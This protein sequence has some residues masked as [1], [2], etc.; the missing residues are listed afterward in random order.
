M[1]EKLLA[2]FSLPTDD[3]DNL[4]FRIIDNG[5][6]PCPRLHIEAILFNQQKVMNLNGIRINPVSLVA[7]LEA[8]G[9]TSSSFTKIVDRID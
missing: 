3:G 6:D 4:E 8:L 7:T 9:I 2:L 1:T 5:I